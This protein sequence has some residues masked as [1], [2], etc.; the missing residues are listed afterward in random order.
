[1]R[2][3]L[4]AFGA[5]ILAGATLTACAQKELTIDTAAVS[6]AVQESVR[7]DSE[8]AAVDESIAQMMFTLPEGVKAE[9]YLG[10][11]ST[12]DE[13][14]FFTCENSAQVKEVA[15]AVDQHLSDVKAAF[16][17]YLPVEADKVNNAVVIEKGNYVVLCVTSDYI[18]AASVIDEKMQ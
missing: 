6:T 4:L 2:R 13:L 16:E 14:A 15:E 10:A 11:G 9:L 17:D 12:A 1:M 5:A 8:L 7:F 18:K 3:S